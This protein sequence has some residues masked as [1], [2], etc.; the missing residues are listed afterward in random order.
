MKNVLVTSGLCLS[1]LLLSA[2][3][4]DDKDINSLTTQTTL[5]G[6]DNHCWMGG[7]RTDSGLDNND[8]GKL[9]S[10]EVVDSSFL[11]VRN[12]GRSS[13]SP[14]RRDLRF[15]K[16]DGVFILRSGDQKDL[17]GA[18]GGREGHGRPR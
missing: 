11:S 16:R 6:G 1:V 7:I 17:F 14:C 13:C 3:N 15:G 9:D 12:G 4:S 5:I 8:N 18:E 10:N 2:C